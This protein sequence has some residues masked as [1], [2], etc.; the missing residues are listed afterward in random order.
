MT[1]KTATL[2]ERLEVLT[3]VFDGF[4]IFVSDS[5]M[6]LRF[7]RSEQCTAY[8]FE[9]VSELDSTERRNVFLIATDDDSMPSYKKLHDMFGNSRALM[10]PL[11]SFDPSIEASKYTLSLIAQ[12]D[13][14]AAT[15][16]NSVWMEKLLY[17]DRTFVLHGHGSEATCK[18]EDDVVVMAPKTTVQLLPG[19]WDTIG[20]Y[21]EVGMVPP[22]DDIRPAFIVNGVLTVPGTAVAHHR[23][24]PKEL[25]PLTYRTWE[26][27]QELRKEG[28]FPLEMHIENSRVTRVLAGDI[29]ISAYLLN[30]TNPRRDLVLT[31]MAF[32]TNKG[33]SSREI[34][35][36]KNSQMN[37]GAI[38]IHVGLGD[39]LTGAHI[40]FICPDVETILQ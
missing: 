27:F 26:L 40:D 30:F 21:F 16:L 29:D 33:V 11:L 8:S 35:W 4:P 5:E 17:D 19:E 6:I 28:R 24:M 10:L 22:P 7:L 20:L 37:E 1:F 18:I 2:R 36:T 15:K 14:D 13:F 25:V 38:G 32:S 39:G 31:E 3:P 12:S 9:E 34:D 23:Q